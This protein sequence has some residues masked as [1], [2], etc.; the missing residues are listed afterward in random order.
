MKLPAFARFSSACLLL[1]LAL[2]FSRMPVYAQGAGVTVAWDPNPEDF[3]AGY[4]VYVTVIRFPGIATEQFDVSKTTQFTFANVTPGVG[5]YF[6]VAAYTSKG[7]VGPRSASVYYRAGSTARSSSSIL[8]LTAEVA[9]GPYGVSDPYVGRVMRPGEVGSPY[10]GG[11]TRPGEVGSPYVGRVFRPGAAAI[12]AICVEGNPADCYAA[13]IL[14]STSAHITALDAFPDGRVALVEDGRVIRIVGAGTDAVTEVALTT[15][16]PAQVILGV[17]VDP[18]FATSRAVYVSSTEQERDGRRSLS[19]VRYREVGGVLAQGAGIVTGLSVPATGAVPF[20][21]DSH[22]RLYVAIPGGDLGGQVNSPYASS[23][24]RFEA[25]GSASPDNGNASPVFARGYAQP[26]ALAWS[27]K[28]RLLWLSGQ[29]ADWA[30]ELALVN[31]ESET[32]AKPRIPSP[33]SFEVVAQRVSADQLRLPTGLT[34]TLLA[35]DDTGTRFVVARDTAGT[36]EILIRLD[37][38]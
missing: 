26:T 20:T 6:S 18:A 7:V 3:V 17:A 12:D 33:A 21:L 36:T 30:G 37:P 2:V 19:I 9:S 27:A 13:H 8:P 22:G 28:D 32:A 15:D 38:R 29:G 31:V 4:Y 14:A 25:D 34:A 1:V 11:V 35:G 10:V 24:L 23:V 16:S 5:Y